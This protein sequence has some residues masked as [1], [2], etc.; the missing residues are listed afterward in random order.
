[1]VT[2]M[3]GEETVGFYDLQAAIAYLNANPKK[4]VWV[5]TMDAPNYPKGEQTNENSVLLILGHPSADWG[6]APLAA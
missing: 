3:A 5:Y 1:N 2:V 4:T 6:Y